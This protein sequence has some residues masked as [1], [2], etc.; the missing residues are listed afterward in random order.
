MQLQQLQGQPT[1]LVPGVQ[2][3]AERLFE[4]PD[5]VMYL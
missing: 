5:E 4:V 2:Q 1:L 3:N